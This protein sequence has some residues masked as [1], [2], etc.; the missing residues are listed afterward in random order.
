VVLDGRRGEDLRAAAGGSGARLSAPQNRD[1][2]T[3]ERTAAAKT[4]IFAAAKSAGTGSLPER[5][6]DSAVENPIMVI[7]TTGLPR[8]D[9]SVA[10][11]TARAL[12]EKPRITM[13]NLAA[14]GAPARDVAPSHPDPNAPG[15]AT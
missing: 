8:N 13:T 12:A 4:A 5:A 1:P 14:S 7:I 2:A 3:A 6:V 15:Y 9:D 11:S 10:M